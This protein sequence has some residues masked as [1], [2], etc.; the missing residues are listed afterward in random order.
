MARP[1][2]WVND[3]P[4]T[5]CHEPGRIDGGNYSLCAPCWCQVNNKNVNEV[6]V[7]HVRERAALAARL[8]SGRQGKEAA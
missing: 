4:C 5:T 7:Q 2:I 8:T 6:R 3:E 1:I